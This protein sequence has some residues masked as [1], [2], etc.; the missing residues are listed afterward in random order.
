MPYPQGAVA[1]M[2]A[3]V[4][5]AVLWLAPTAVVAATLEV[6]PGDG[7]LAAA[8]ERAEAGDRLLLGAG[9]Y[10]G[11]VV[12]ERTVILEGEDGATV[13]GGGAGTVI[14]VDAPDVVVRGLTIVNSGISLAEEHA[15]VFVTEAAD[16]ALIER[17]RL[18]SNLI[19]VFLKGPEKAIVR[20]NTI[21]GRQDLRMNERGNG[22]HLWNTPGSQVVGN[23]IRYGRD[24][25]FVTTSRDNRFEANSF[26]NLRFA[27]HYMYTQAS[28][29]VGNLSEGNHVGYALMYSKRISAEDNVSRGDRD[30]GLL[31][32]Y[33]NESTIVGNQVFGSEKCVFIYNANKN[34]FQ[35][36][37]FQNCEIGVHFTAGSERNIISGNAFI[38]NRTQVKYVGTRFLDWSAEGRGNYWSDNPAFDLDG[39]G[40]ADRTYRPNDITDE[41]LWAHPAAKLLLNS[42]AM[43]VLRYAQSQFPAL[44]PGGVRD[45]APLMHPPLARGDPGEKG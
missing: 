38:D 5:A 45:S 42:P 34:L 33:V 12:L 11:P 13:D 30:R 4:A 37:H 24:G 22:V 8:L 2:A 32:N 26:R 29:V 21:V 7:T 31:L 20:A 1:R 6:R 9:R 14:T 23:D 39:D 35:D 18:E 16:R 15:G 10:R 36:N 27:V 40:I 19:G 3:V 43:Q 44:H 25:I 41:I 17:N 28:E